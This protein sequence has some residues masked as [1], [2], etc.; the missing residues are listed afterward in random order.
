[1]VGASRKWFAVEQAALGAKRVSPSGRRVGS[2]TCVSSHWSAREYDHDP[3]N[4][5]IAAGFVSIVYRAARERANKAS[6]A[7]RRYQSSA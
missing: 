5:A 4:V 6:P 1:M 3:P 2:A 7:E